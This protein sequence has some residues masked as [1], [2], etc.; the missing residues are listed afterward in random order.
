MFVAENIAEKNNV[1]TEITIPVFV[2]EQSHGV[3]QA[4]HVVPLSPF[5]PFEPITQAAFMEEFPVPPAMPAEDP[6]AMVAEN[7][8]MEIP[9]NDKPYKPWGSTAMPLNALSSHD[10]SNDL[11]NDMFNNIEVVGHTEVVESPKEQEKSAITF[12]PVTSSIRIASDNPARQHSQPL[13]PPVMTW[14]AHTVSAQNAAPVQDT[15]PFNNAASTPEMLTSEQQSVSQ[16]VLQASVITPKALGH[17]VPMPHPSL[18][19][20]ASSSKTPWQLLPLPFELHGEQ[21]LLT[22]APFRGTLELAA[23]FRIEMIGDTKLCILPPDP[24][25][26]P[27]IFVD[28]GRIIIHPLQAN[29]PLRIETEQSRGTV[30]VTGMN[31]ILFIDTFAEISDPSGNIKP[32]MGQKANTGPILGVVPKNGERI[33]WQSI[34]QPNPFYIETQGSVLL[35]SEQYRFGNVHNLPN[36]LGTMPMSQEDRML[37]ETCRRHFINARGNTE[38]SLIEALTWLIQDE[39]RTVRALGLRLWG[40]FGRFDVP[41]M[42]MAER[43]PEDEGV[44][45]IL[46]QYFN[47]VMRRDEET[48]LRLANAIDSLREARK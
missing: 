44:R 7:S 9:A 47:E 5:P 27:G 22:A 6:F 2:E 40:D 35:H 38:E 17:A 25:G 43:S 30:R 16:P 13:S 19:F 39:S 20:S 8:S 31:S 12:Q 23:S 29:Q 28:Y 36:W 33:I 48:I 42:A 24:S 37:A 1:P 18:I 21:Y 32:P 3:E 41:L 15:V 10:L 11:P 34:R 45:L 46:G 4:V 26:I 14:Q